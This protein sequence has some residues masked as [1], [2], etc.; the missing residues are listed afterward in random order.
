MGTTSS[1]TPKSSGGIINGSLAVVD[2][3]DNLL[4]V[5]DDVLMNILHEQA[6][7]TQIDLREQARQSDTGWVDVADAI[8]VQYDH[9]NRQFSYTITGDDATQEH[10]M[11]LE[12]GNGHLAPT[13][14][15]RGTILQQQ[16]KVTADI[17]SK[18]RKTLLENF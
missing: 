14:L 3:V 1:R 8:S 9:D 6:Q 16:D 4:R 5:Y 18:L 7:Q 10:A 17:N 15:L 11:N 13:P 12:Y 2:Y